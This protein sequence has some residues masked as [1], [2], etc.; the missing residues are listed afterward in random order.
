[1]AWSTSRLSICLYVHVRFGAVA[2][3]PT[4]TELFAYVYA[5]P[6]SNFNTALLEVAEGDHHT[7]M[8]DQ[9]MVTS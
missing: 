6:W 3:V 5:L 9:H 2:G 8:L 1:M 4:A 7:A